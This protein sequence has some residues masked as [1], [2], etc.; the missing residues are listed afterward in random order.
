MRQATTATISDT[1]GPAAAMRPR[2]LEAR[3]ARWT[4]QPLAASGEGQPADVQL[5]RR[6]E[7]DDDQHL[8]ARER[9]R[10]AR[11]R[12]LVD[13]HGDRHGDQELEQAGQGRLHTI[14][15]RQETPGLQA[16]AG[17]WTRR[18]SAAGS[19]ELLCAADPASAVEESAM[20]HQDQPGYASPEE[21]RQQPPEEVIY[22]ACLYEGTG[23]SE[24]DFIATVDANPESDTYSQI[25]HRTPMPNVGDELHHF[26]WNVCSSACHSDLK[27]DTMI[28]PGV[29]SSRVHIVDVSDPRKPE[30]AK[31]IEPDEV[32]G[33]SGLSWPHTVHC[34]PGDI[35]TMSML[36]DA[37]GS[38]T[39]SGTR[40]GTTR[41]CRPS[42]ARRTPSRTGSTPRTWAQASTG[43][44]CTSGTWSARPRCR[45]STS[46]PRA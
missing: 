7:A 19:P 14:R 29:R 43:R 11:V 41:C 36:G 6:A 21:A 39:T 31:V 13:E 38:A 9:E 33:K 22:V 35:I 32:I 37:D 27:R 3:V 4:Q 45:R 42:G 1:M 26:G 34:M 23:I 30:V 46:A 28:V 12:E 15:C 40:R 20:S 17:N 18:G 8:P 25:I 44:S 2:S 5:H 10:H 24:P 16:P